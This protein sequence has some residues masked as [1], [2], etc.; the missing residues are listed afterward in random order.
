M[1]IK[2]HAPQGKS[3]EDVLHIIFTSYHDGYY[4]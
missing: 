4:Y 1:N 3:Y 2:N